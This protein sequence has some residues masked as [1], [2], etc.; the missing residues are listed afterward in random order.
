MMLDSLNKALLLS[1]RQHQMVFIV[2]LGL[3]AVV[4]FFLLDGW[5]TFWPIVVWS[6][7]FGVHFIIYRSQVVDEQW[8]EERM[9]FDVYRPWDYGHIEEIKKN[10]YGKSIFRTE[11]G[12]V[13][14][15]GNPVKPRD[16]EDAGENTRANRD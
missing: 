9:I 6:M 13:D 10:P 16:D 2:A 3:M 7:L 4:D 5:G 15:D 8:L 14:K 11:I 12:R 1:F